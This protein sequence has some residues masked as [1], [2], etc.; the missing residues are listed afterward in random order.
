[1]LEPG[2]M[3][4]GK[5]KIIGKIG[6]GGMSVV[7]LA[8]N[9]RANKYWAVK[10]VRKDG[11]KD[12]EV[13]RQGLAAETD[14]LKKLRHPNLPD[15][16]DVIE[17]ESTFLIVMDYI[18]GRPLSRILA[19]QG[20]QPQELV[21]CWAK[22][23]CDVLNYLHTRTPSIIYR[24]MKPANIMLKP[25]K[26]VSLIDFGTARE[27]K[28]TSHSDTTCL[29]TVG[30]AAPE[31]FGGMGETDA[32]TDIY[33]LGTT[34]YHLVT[35]RNPCDY[36]Y[37]MQPIRE[38]FP[39]LSGGLEQIIQ[40]CTQRNPQD[41]YQSCSELKY[42]LEHYKE[43]D[44]AYRKK[45]K[46]KLAVF[47]MC[48]AAAVMCGTISAWGYAAGEQKKSAD[49]NAVLM[50]ASTCEDYYD[51]ILTDPVRMDAYL[52]LTDMLTADLLLTREEGKQLWKLKLGLDRKEKGGYL[53]HYDVMRQLK[54]GNPD[55]YAEVCYQI[56]DAFLAYYDVDVDRD[57]YAAA[58]KWFSE[59]QHT[60]PAAKIY[61][62]ISDCLELI[63]QYSGA[64]IK[65]SE[66]VY[67]EYE[68]L[69][70]MMGQLSENAAILK[71][72][73]VK[74]QI[75]RE[76]NK[77]IAAQIIPLLEVVSKQ[78]II[79]LLNHISQE[80][81]KIHASVLLQEISELRSDIADTIQKIDAAKEDN[82]Q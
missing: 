31:Q 35:G 55:G 12:Y 36:P 21:V 82:K 77:M 53:K 78:E 8:V 3:I 67:K 52:E 66:K 79:S 57:R 62:D 44:E 80:S 20:A 51:A 70:E 37:E 69:W 16:V 2:Q 61:C 24:D 49:Y 10:E 13:I 46:H 81:Q 58:K 25:D 63:Y 11:V 27:F 73:D 74:M 17:D 4:D 22:Q 41:R 43:L 38:V 65:R 7:Y 50:R 34:L 48:V 30:Y 42:A 54:D 56:G 59:T 76:T 14:L 60:D 45:Q 15:I 47:A 6:Q 39:F 75:W 23:L 72:A 29:G 71:S 18:E 32:R 1:M 5:Y 68:K 9:E 33:C 19:E 28:G 64:K 40:K 26:S